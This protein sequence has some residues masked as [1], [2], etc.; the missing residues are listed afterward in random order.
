MV[1]N[2][3]LHDLAPEDYDLLSP[4]LERIQAPAHTPICRQGD[5]ALYLYL[6]LDGN[7]SL[8]YKPYD[9]PRI[10]LTQLHSGDVFGWSSV[11]GNIAYTS[12]AIS[13]TPVTALR[14][15]GTALRRL[16]IEHPVAG[17]QIL[18]KLAIAVS[19][20]WIHSRQQVQGILQ[21]EVFVRS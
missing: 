20:R 7:V 9:G 12:D 4:I 15:R 8:R 16:C 19:P 1:D 14:V 18:E 17:A 13:S 11:I 10:T 21:T 2:P 3:F 6:L 5:A